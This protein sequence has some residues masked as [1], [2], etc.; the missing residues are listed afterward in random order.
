[1]P[2][3]ESSSPIRGERYTVGLE[4]LGWVGTGFRYKDAAELV[5]VAG[6]NAVLSPPHF[7]STRLE[8]PADLLRS[9][10]WSTISEGPDMTFESDTRRRDR[11]SAPP[12]GRGSSVVL[13]LAPAEEE[14]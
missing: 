14:K 11:R 6:V 4:A 10:T 7:S 13:L 1:M 3:C 9:S 2:G 5:G 12:R 8:M